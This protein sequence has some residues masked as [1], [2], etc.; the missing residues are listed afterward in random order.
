VIEA[1]SLLT[2]RDPPENRRGKTTGGS[3]QVL[4]E[5]AVM[6][7]FAFWLFDSLDAQSVEIHPDGEH[8]K[9]FDIRGWLEEHGFQLQ[10]ALGSTN[11]G[12][13]YASGDR[14]LVVH[15]KSG[16][17]DV[18]AATNRDKVVAECKGGILNTTHPGQLSHLRSGP[19]RG[20]RAVDDPLS[21]R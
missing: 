13:V 20:G 11:Y 4:T 3:E 9:R 14:T 6:L 1:E 17:G 16:L 19:V 12:G 5:A 15:P 8:G 21:G 7:A 10:S 2:L 18:V